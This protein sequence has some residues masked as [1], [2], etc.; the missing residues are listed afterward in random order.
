MPS[1]LPSM[2]TSSQADRH[3]DRHRQQQSEHCLTQKAASEATVNEL[4][5]LMLLSPTLV[6]SILDGQQS[7]TLCLLWLKNHLPPSDWGEQHVLFD[8]FDA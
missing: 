4:L 2:L 7:K 3:L 8:G 5:R 6:R 1:Q